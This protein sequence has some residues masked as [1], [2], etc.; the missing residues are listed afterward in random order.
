[1]LLKLNVKKTKLLKIGKMQ[2]DAGVSVDDE[3]IE[4]VEHFKYLGSL[5]SV[6]GRIVDISSD[7]TS[8]LD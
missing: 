6:G 3:A 1:M 7:V 4:V 2:C 8:Q 5:K